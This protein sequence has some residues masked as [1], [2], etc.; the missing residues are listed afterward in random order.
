MID[1]INLLLKAK[2]ITARQFAEEIGI[3]PSGI[4]HILSGRNNP[5]LDFVLK[6]MKRWPEINIS[7][8]MFGKGEM[9]VSPSEILQTTVQPQA[10]NQE[11]AESQPVE[12]DLFSQP[13]LTA[14]EQASQNDN[15]SVLKYK[16]QQSGKQEVSSSD[17]NTPLPH[18]PTDNPAEKQSVVTQKVVKNNEPP[19]ADEISTKDPDKVDVPVQVNVMTKKRIQKI[20]V[21]YDDHSFAEYFPE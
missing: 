8:L 4:S 3:Q 2:N 15:N 14:E 10:I 7:W 20:V 1:R 9:Y 13:S 19:K 21:L 11:T 18:I 5:S 12:Y 16:M 17:M 6:V